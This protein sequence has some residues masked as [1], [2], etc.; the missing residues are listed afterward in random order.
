MQALALSKC[1]PKNDPLK[2]QPL[3][4]KNGSVRFV[5]TGITG[6]NEMFGLMSM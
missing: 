2:V 3:V 6:L 5:L 1:Q 4:L